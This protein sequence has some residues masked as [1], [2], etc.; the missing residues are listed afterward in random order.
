MSKINQDSAAKHLDLWGGGLPPE[1]LELILSKLI[2]VVDIQKFHCVCK[3][4]QSIT[5]SVSPPRQLRS[6]LPYAD[7]S[8]PLLFQINEQNDK[9]RVSHPLYN[10]TWD[11]EFPPTLIR[12]DKIICFSKYGWSLMV[13]LQLQ[14]NSMILFLFNPLTQEIKLLPTIPMDFS[15]IYLG[16]RSMFFTCPPSHPDCSIVAI[17]SI[18]GV[19]DVQDFSWIVYDEVLPLELDTESS[20]LISLVEHNG[21]LLVV[22]IGEDCPYV[23]EFDL[24]RKLCVPMKSLGKNALFI[25]KGASFSQKAI[26]SGTGNKIFGPLVLKN[27]TDS[28]RFYSL[29]TR[30]IHSFFDN[31][32]SDDFCDMEFIKDSSWLPM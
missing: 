17:F 20:R 5:V 32:S 12:G 11:F 2:F 30:K 14:Q 8:F 10:Y 18:G 1:L 29:A 25:S 26:V 22:F 31:L 23:F 21:Q 15:I 19:F 7:S 6:P 13:Q 3:T 24:K 9:Y 27:K 16:L 4:W 28:F